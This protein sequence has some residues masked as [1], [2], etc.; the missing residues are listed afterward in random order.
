MNWGILSQSSLG[1]ARSAKPSRYLKAITVRRVRAALQEW[2]TTAHGW[3]TAWG[4][5]TRSTSSC[6]WFTFLLDQHMLLS[7]LRCRAII[8]TTT[9]VLCLFMALRSCCH[10][11]HCSWLYFLLYLW[12]WCFMIKFH[13]FLKTCQ[14]SISLNTKG[15]SKQARNCNKKK[16]EAG[17]TGRAYVKWCPADT[18]KASMSGGWCQLI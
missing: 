8:V 14:P 6:F 11:L 4:I 12:L 9:R 7:W 18:I 5:I 16:P 17:P 10:V 3:T 13:A 1:P 2:T 15:R